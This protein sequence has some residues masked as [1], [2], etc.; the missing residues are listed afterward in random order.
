MEEIGYR[1]ALIRGD[2]CRT[3]D[4]LYDEFATA[5]K[6]GE[7][8]EK[9]IPNLERAVVDLEEFRLSRGVIIV[10]RSPEEFLAD[11]PPWYFYKLIRAFTHAFESWYQGRTSE[12]PPLLLHVILASEPDRIEQTR[13]HWANPIIPLMDTK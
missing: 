2:H 12:R 10:I 5:L 1:S 6:F 13:R 9:T 11:L 4:A 3:I 8:F 7:S